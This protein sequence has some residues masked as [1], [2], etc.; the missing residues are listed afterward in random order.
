M[1][2]PRPPSILDVAKAA[3]VSTA[4]VS[5]VLNTPKLV[6][7]ETAARVQ[8]AIFGLGYRPNIFAQGLM[9]RKSR[10]IGFALPDIHGEFY[11]ELLRGADA[12]AR[13][14]G[15]HLLVSSDVR[16]GDGG[17]LAS[18]TAGLIGGL[19][20]M[21]TE[22]GQRLW[23]EGRAASVPVVVI[24]RDVGDSGVDCVVI[25]NASGTRESVAHLLESVPA[26]HCY[27][28]GGPKENFDTAQRAAAFEET[29]KKSRGRVHASQVLFNEYSARWGEAAITQILSKEGQNPVG[30][31]AGN[32]EIAFGAMQAARRLGVDIPGRLRI[33]GFDD[34]RL[35][36]L[37]TPRLSSVRVPMAQVG[38]TAIQALARR[39]H[40]P[41]ANLLCTRL[42]T[43][44][45]VRDS[46]RPAGN[47]AP[48]DGVRPRTSG[49]ARR[50]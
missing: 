26:E 13:R 14:L 28:I 21:V 36:S 23:K 46:S 35:A 24:D 7:P 49:P 12:E 27:F 20:V 39:L 44:L 41:E 33:I 6:A 15:Y 25:D 2:H 42:S 29:L 22:P 30:V 10:I 47:D 4:T 38:E 48:A 45:V 8:Q 43:T 5:R 11:S 3:G 32:D 9:T 1:V 19:A 17:L 37:V 40:D 34:T 50:R 16:D 31:L 18:G